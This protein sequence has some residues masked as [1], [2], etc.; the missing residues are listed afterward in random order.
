MPGKA[1]TISPSAE[2]LVEISR[3]ASDMKDRGG[4]RPMD[5]RAMA[6]SPLSPGE[7]SPPNQD[8]RLLANAVVAINQS[9]LWPGRALRIH[10][11]IPTQR[12]TVQIVNSETEDVLDQIPAEEV[13][14]MAM[15]LGGNPSSL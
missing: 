2:I 10:V 7:I 14:R 12:L 4:D 9:T 15:E 13:L 11:D 8:R 5:V 6:M 3:G 1:S